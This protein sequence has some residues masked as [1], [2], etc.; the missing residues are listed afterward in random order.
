MEKGLMEK[1][2]VIEAK[3]AERYVEKEPILARCP[4]CGE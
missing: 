3:Q 1:R 2:R 4:E